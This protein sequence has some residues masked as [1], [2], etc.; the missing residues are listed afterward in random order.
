MDSLR[1]ATLPMLARPSDSQAPP[2]TDAR[3]LGGY[4]RSANLKCGARD[5]DRANFQG[6]TGI[7]EMRIE[8]SRNESHANTVGRR[9]FPQSRGEWG[10]L[11]LLP[12]AGH[13]ARISVRVTALS[14]GRDR[15]RHV[16][17]QREGGRHAEGPHVLERLPGLGR[18]RPLPRHVL[19][20]SCFLS[21]SPSMFSSS[22]CRSSR[23]SPSGMPTDFFSQSQCLRCC[24]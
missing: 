16:L 20:L 24:Q 2:L 7:S 10:E 9:M 1:R 13:L 21:R 6:S 18:E 11:S 17:L 23:T 12:R 22:L 3:A 5:R 4:P 15:R 14:S 19:G 8:T